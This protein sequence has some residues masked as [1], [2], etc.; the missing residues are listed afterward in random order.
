VRNDQVNMLNL[1]GYICEWGGIALVV[2][3][4]MRHLLKNGKL[5]RAVLEMWLVFI[6][7]LVAGF[8]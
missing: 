8:E 5:R 4:P 1:F 3:F 6:R 7:P 2:F